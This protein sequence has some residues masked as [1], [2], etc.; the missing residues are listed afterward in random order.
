MRVCCRDRPH[1]TQP[2]P[3]PPPG[4]M[5]LESGPAASAADRRHAAGGTKEVGGSAGGPARTDA[6]LRGRKGKRSGH[7]GRLLLAGPRAATCYVRVKLT[8]L[9]L[10]IDLR[11]RPGSGG[12][13]ADS[14]ISE[15]EEGEEFWAPWDVVVGRSPGGYVLR[16]VVVEIGLAGA[17]LFLFLRPK[18]VSTSVVARW[19]PRPSPGPWRRGV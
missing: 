14:S 18:F 9:Q 11:R 17:D 1:R 10:P 6:N 13:L 12:A 7:Y 2:L 5:F 15:G 3:L 8:I 19:T 16:E 4:E